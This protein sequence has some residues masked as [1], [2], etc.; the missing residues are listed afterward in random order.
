MD[1][2][3]SIMGQSQT[4]WLQGQM[5]ASVATWQVLAQQV[6]MG[7]MM[8][9]AELLL[10]IAQLEHASGDTKTALLTQ[11][12]TMLTELYTIKMRLD[13]GDPSV[14]DAEKARLSTVVPYNLDAWDGYGYNREVVLQT[15][16]TLGKNLIVLSGD[17]H[18]AWAN[19]L[20]MFDAS[21]Q[22][23]IPVGVEFATTSVTSPGME[24]YAG[25]TTD[26][27]AQ[28]FETVITAIIDD[29]N[30]FNANNRGFMTVTFTHEA[31]QAEWVFVD[32]NATTAYTTLPARG[33][34]LKTLKGTHTIIPA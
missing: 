5:A 9:P 28:Q 19:E 7:R 2:N 25:L 13:M 20:K 31:A 33:K 26:A 22:P 12:A 34:K 24:E 17:T 10:V 30:Y 6:L 15:A 4:L 32:S 1:T 27:A 8:L 16:A 23:T 18:N 14:T 3:R 21:Y 11:L 29:L